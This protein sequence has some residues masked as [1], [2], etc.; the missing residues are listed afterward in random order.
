[1]NRAKA[2]LRPFH[3]SGFFML[4]FLG[5]AAALGA[6]A[7]WSAGADSSKSFSDII[8]GRWATIY[9]KSF[10]KALY[11]YDP[12][13]TGWAI[14]TYAAFREGSEGVLVG[15]NG[16]LFTAE[17]FAHVPD[18]KRKVEEKADLIAAVRDY[19]GERGA[20][21]VV[22][23]V[24]AKA[25]I[26][27]AQ[28][29]PYSFPSYKKEVYPDFIRALQKRRVALADPLPLMEAQAAQT[30]LF[31][32]TDTHWT[33]QGAEIAATIT[34]AFVSR[35]VPGLDYER[36]RYETRVNGKKDHSG[37]LLRYI[38]VAGAAE[39]LGIAS[40]RLD[41]VQTTRAGGASGQDNLQLALFS[42]ETPPVTLVG[43]SYSA[44]AD[45]NFEGYLRENLGLDVLNAAREGVGPFET[46]KNYLGNSAFKI[47]PP[48]LV[49]WEIPERYLTFDYDLRAPYYHK[50]A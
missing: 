44:N 46:M 47:S 2:K 16:W 29:Y 3:I 17:E 34:G 13:K 10:N 35:H 36:R 20:R 21:L 38:P 40:D 4:A 49:I 19:L 6:S 18:A 28:L 30:P 23:P 32:K 42:D 37:D 45:W 26:Y 9:E 33:P 27:A 5:T 14:L 50:G 7:V 8:E 22:V 15:Q 24:P 12:S 25:R 39:S 31:L 41:I 43:T 48:A 1:M 11:I